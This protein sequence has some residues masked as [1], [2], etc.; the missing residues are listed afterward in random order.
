LLTPTI[1][2]KIKDGSNKEKRKTKGKHKNE[3]AIPRENATT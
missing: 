3:R 1:L 2:R